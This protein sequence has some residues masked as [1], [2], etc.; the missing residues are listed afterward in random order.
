[1]NRVDTTR[2]KLKKQRVESM[3]Q[4]AIIMKT[5]KAAQDVYKETDRNLKGPQIKPGIPGS[6]NSAIGEMPV[7][8]RWANLSEALTMQPV[9]GNL[10]GIFTDTRKAKYDKFVHDG[11]PKMKPRRYLGDAI[12]AKRSQ[13]ESDFREV[14]KA[15]RSVGQS[16]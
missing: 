9:Q 14:I 6:E 3:M 10:Y 11:T 15:I 16:L 7:P 12:D 4:K 2:W 8:R 13:V 5:L 1:M